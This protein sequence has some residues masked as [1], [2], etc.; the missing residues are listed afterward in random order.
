MYSKS[1]QFFVL[2]SVLY[3]VALFFFPVQ[4]SL[5]ISFFSIFFLNRRNYIVIAFIFSLF[6]LFYGMAMD[7][8]S[9]IGD[10][11][12]YYLTFYQ[13]DINILVLGKLYRYLIFQFISF[14]GFE[15]QLYTGITLFL[16]FFAILF[17]SLRF[18]DIFSKRRKVDFILAFILIVLLYPST[19]IGN[20]ES[21]FSFTLVYLALYLFCVGKK[22]RSL[23]LLVLAPLVHP[24]AILYSAMMLPALLFSRFYKYKTLLSIS[25]FSVIV[26]FALFPLSFIG[27]FIV[28]IQNKLVFFLTGPWSQYVERRDFEFFIIAFLKFSILI[29]CMIRIKKCFYNLDSERI[30]P[31]QKLLLVIGRLYNTAFYIMPIAFLAVFSRTLN[32][33]YIYFGLFFFLPIV[34]LGIQSYRSKIN[35]LFI[36]LSLFLIF[37][38]PQNIIVFGVLSSKSLTPET[39][40][41]NVVELLHKEY[42]KAP[43]AVGRL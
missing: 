28:H 33:R 10:Y 5:F 6:F 7:P 29:F 31:N 41:L 27:S 23:L 34:L 43:P 12:R 2:G 37:A 35:R 36:Y 26:M 38:L 3:L 20:Y 8:V 42:E 30:F 40:S 15:P 25:A 14:F 24:A 39:L 1:K 9:Y 22:K 11:S 13:P 21:M 4:T 17:V 16:N 32:E 18:V 19:A